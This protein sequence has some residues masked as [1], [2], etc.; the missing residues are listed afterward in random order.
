MVKRQETCEHGRGPSPFGPADCRTR[1]EPGERNGIHTREDTPPGAILPRFLIAGL[2]GKRAVAER[3][4]KKMRLGSTETRTPNRKGGRS[5]VFRASSRGA[6][7]A[8]FRPRRFDR[9]VSTAAFRPPARG[10]VFCRRP[11]NRALRGG[12][13]AASAYRSY[14]DRSI[15][16]SISRISDA[17]LTRAQRTPRRPC[18]IGSKGPSRAEGRLCLG[19][20]ER[21]RVGGIQQVVLC[22]RT[23]PPEPPQPALALHVFGYA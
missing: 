7:I 23:A 14:R 22:P 1:P 21:R 12:K 5:D 8:A 4:A 18:R 19:E 6:S 9:G 20:P 11:L 15:S 13:R 17:I 2:V 3:P 10:R 16:P